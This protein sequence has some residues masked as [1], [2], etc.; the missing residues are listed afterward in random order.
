MMTP[1]PRLCSFSERGCGARR[2]PRPRGVRGPSSSVG[3]SKNC[4]KVGLSK[5]DIIELRRTILLERI[6][7]TLGATFFTTGAKLVRAGP[8]LATGAWFSTI[9]GAL[10]VVFF[11]AA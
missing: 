5:G 9:L 3:G 8:D 11:S 7:T 1:E 4:R 6:V 10:W 2:P